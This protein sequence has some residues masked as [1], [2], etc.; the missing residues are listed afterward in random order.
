M[1]LETLGNLG[2]FFGGIAV[3]A[4]LIYL[5]VQIRANTQATQSE[6][7]AG[8]AREYREINQAEGDPEVAKMIGEGLNNYPDMPHERMVP[9]GSWLNNQ[10]LFFQ[11]VFARYETGQLEEETYQAYLNWYASL[12]STP[13]GR[14]WFD[15]TVRP[16]Y[17]PQM[18]L[19]V[20]A[21][22]H[23]GGLFDATTI[24]PY[25]WSDDD[26]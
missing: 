24:R 8:V 23:E 1:N 16:I 25:Q 22:I 2:D 26:K 10:S 11:G 12:V 15:E 3:I 14:R 6:N 17:A 13:G 21:R 5:A 20:D 18:V 9:Y 19:A 7:R 4:T